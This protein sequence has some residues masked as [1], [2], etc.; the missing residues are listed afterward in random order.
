M[1]ISLV[2]HFLPKIWE[3]RGSRESIAKWKLD[4]QISINREIGGSKSGGVVS[5]S[6]FIKQSLCIST[7]VPREGG[8][9]LSCQV[10]EIIK[11]CYTKI[12]TTRQISSLTQKGNFNQRLHAEVLPGD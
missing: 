4:H 10:Y 3:P 8:G 5:L 12:N 7:T 6:Y 11:K 2:L 1:R 9:R